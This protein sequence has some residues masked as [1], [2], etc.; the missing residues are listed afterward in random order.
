[1]KFLVFSLPKEDAK[2][3]IE[4]LLTPTSL[5]PNGPYSEPFSERSCSGSKD[6]FG[7][8]FYSLPRTT[9]LWHRLLSQCCTGNLRASWY[10]KDTPA[11]LSPIAVEGNQEVSYI[12]MIPAG[13]ATPLAWYKY[14]NSQKCPKVLKGGCERCFPASGVRVPKYSLA[15]CETP[16]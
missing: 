8:E 12:C 1:M 14:L 3:S 11:I 9:P 6:L 5:Y 2:I 13:V 7:G 16:F 15:R 10:R 4:L